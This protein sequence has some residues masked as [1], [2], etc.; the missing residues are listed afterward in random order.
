MDRLFAPADALFGRLS[1][2]W[3]ITLASVLVI[4]PV[5]Y[6]MW[7]NFDNVEQRVIQLEERRSGLDYL[8]AARQLF[9]LVPQHRGLSQSVLNGNQAARSD[10]R[11]AAQKVT[12]A[13]RAL[14]ETDARL[15]GSLQT[16]ERLAKVLSNL[17]ALLAAGLELT[18][19]T[20]FDRHNEVI[21]ALHR[22]VDHV[23]D[24]SGLST[25]HDLA[26]A[27]LA[28]SMTTE[29]LMAAE[30]AGRMRGLGTGIA[31]KGAFT[32][33]TFT[34]LSSN[35]D[36]LLEYQA[37]IANH[38][39]H[40]EEKRPQLI[41]PLGGHV[42]EMLQALHGFAGF[43]RTRML[44]PEQLQATP[45]EVFRLG[46]RTIAHLFD[47]FEQGAGLL[48]ADIDQRSGALR[49]R[50]AWSI[51]ITG[52]ALLMLAY[53]GAGFHRTLTRSVAEIDRVT[54]LVAD[55]QLDSLIQVTT[56][57]EMLQIQNSINAMIK[58]VRELVSGMV[59]SAS[60][61]VEGS[62]SIAKATEQT[63]VAMNSQQS[64]VGQVATAVNEM[65]ATVQEVARSAAH[66]AEATAEASQLVSHSKDTVDGNAA[67]IGALAEEVEHAT[68]VVTQV[69]SDSLEIGT[70]L[71]VI[72]A[73]AEQTNLLALNAA[74]EAA[75]AGEQGRGFAVVADEVRT[76]AARTQQ[77]TQE[78][79]GMITRLQ[80][81][82]RQAVEV[83]QESRSRADKG[84]QEAARTNEALS[85]ITEAINRIADM[86]SQIAAAAEEQSAATEEINQSV[87]VINDSSHAAYELANESA[88]ASESL[89]ASAQ[90]L[91]RAT[92]RFRL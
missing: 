34:A 71:D 78:I 86:S 76:L 6:L 75:R 66:T 15:G 55:G 48:A 2:T 1:L 50:E 20:S 10:L 8:A 84:V 30:Y 83:M 14:R 33:S 49:Q 11:A 79:Q 12:T 46:T 57:D 69:E 68:G 13:A 90:E 73:I 67:A 18:P 23:A 43:V 26:S 22:L 31:A 80:A 64:Q 53:L 81:G 88:Q 58:T 7:L 25:D 82:T 36:A 24:E 19:A 44:E 45:D 41:A 4:V 51:G 85:T 89:D 72:R 60:T 28:R 74:I 37:S 62:G 27:L 47:L 16:G 3:K 5:S 59:A 70:V 32:P 40:I 29:M 9:E 92:G 39:Q 54:R 63:R 56:R 61:V 42:S 87:V 52:L 17:E 35:L 91:T 21:M 65:A 77:S 38:F